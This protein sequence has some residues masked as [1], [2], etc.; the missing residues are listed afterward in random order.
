MSF[1][2]STIIN[3]RLILN[4][5]IKFQVC[6]KDLWFLEVE[7]PP[8]SSRVSLVRASTNTLEICWVPTPTAVAYVL[9]VQKIDQPTPQPDKV[10][11]QQQIL[12]KITHTVQ[13]SLVEAV[14]LRD[15]RMPPPPLPKAPISHTIR[16]TSSPNATP[17]LSTGQQTFGSSGS[18]GIATPVSISQSGQPIIIS[19]PQNVPVLAGKA[20]VKSVVSSSTLQQGVRLVN[21]PTSNV[22]VISGNQTVRLTQGGAVAQSLN[23]TILRQQ[24][25]IVSSHAASGSI[26]NAGTVTATS[27]GGKQI[28][29]QKPI[30]LSGQNVLQLVKTSQGMAVQ[31]M[32]KVNVSQKVGT[33]VGGTIQ[34]IPAGSQIVTSGVNNQGKTALIGTNVVKLMSPANKILMKNSNL[35]H[36][37]KMST[38]AGK[39]A[40]VITN[41]Q[42]QTIRT[43]QQ[44]IFVTSAGGIRTVQ[45]SAV[46]AS[47]GNT[48]VSVVSSPQMNTIS[49]AVA[50]GTQQGTMK[51]IRGVGQQGKPITFTLPVGGLQG[52]KG[53]SPQIISMPQKSLT[54]GGKAVTVQLAGNQKTV[55]IVSSSATGGIQ[56][57][58]NASDLQSGGHKIVMM[59]S[60][61]VANISNV[62]THKTVQI[63]SNNT[64]E[65]H[66]DGGE[67]SI[68]G[69]HLEAIDQMDGAFDD[70]SLSDD[71]KSKNKF[72][73][74][75]TIRKSTR[76]KLNRKLK[77]SVPKY[78]KMGL[79]GGSPPEEEETTEPATTS[80][81]TAES[82]EN[83]EEASEDVKMEEPT[84]ENTSASE[85][86]ENTNEEQQSAEEAPAVEASTDETSA[87]EG[88]VDE[89]PAE[90]QHGESVADASFESAM[91]FNE[92]D[93]K[94][95]SASEEHT[96]MAV[97]ESSQPQQQP[98]SQTRNEPTPS[99]TEAANI[100]TT[101]KSGDMLRNTEL[102]TEN[103]LITTT[104]SSSLKSISSSCED[105]KILFNNEPAIITTS[106]NGSMKS[107]QK[108]NNSFITANTGH[109][110]ALAS[111]ALQASSGTDSL[112]VAINEQKPFSASKS[113]IYNNEIDDVSN[114]IVH[115]RQ[116]LLF[117]S[118]YN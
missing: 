10:P 94:Q 75:T 111:A 88:S 39:P 32:P 100:L 101:I 105:V 73:I 17:I 106:K 109:L 85:L 78:V 22:R 7:V 76:S 11:A 15:E 86:N 96:T 104:S 26:A 33:S 53:G 1:G 112:T 27:I 74:N 54:I 83:V 16:L 77:K 113:S 115:N 50:G 70:D 93:D 18:S 20:T 65:S 47:S 43:N 59:P 55:Q 91:E 24:S 95:S 49:S 52:A 36:V 3:H 118:T 110:D 68:D 107:S 92:T 28:F 40:F 21:T 58:I 108:N 79:F 63:S 38:A 6:C 44:F 42:G 5:K 80:N 64:S 8:V 71:G 23:T 84:E 89:T 102:K 61:R 29:V 87:T 98:Q 103:M 35:V 41:K 31:S 81:E 13:S 48:L 12:K 69:S 114:R 4:L 66:D 34:Q 25:T 57:T 9:E 67:G 72:P 45:T 51:M 82:T 14:V 19:S 90:E 2:I 116:P 56:K 99:D 30:S 46:A 97:E 60:K 62:I 37:G 117:H